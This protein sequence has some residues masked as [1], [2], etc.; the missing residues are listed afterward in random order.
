MNK[1]QYPKTILELLS[2]DN[3]RLRTAMFI[4]ERDMFVLKAFIDGYFFALD[5]E[6]IEERGETSFYK[7]HDFTADYFGWKESTAGWH[8]IIL[9]ECNENHS[10]AID[11]FFEVYDKFVLKQEAT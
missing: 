11:K 3:F 2:S 8:R 10:N 6:D 5:N 4:G 7:F 1:S 9:E